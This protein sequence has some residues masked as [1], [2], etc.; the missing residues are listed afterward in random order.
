MNA[1]LITIGTLIVIYAITVYGLNVIVGYAGQ[2]SLG[3]AAF[4]GI[5]AYAAAL[6]STK[7]G[8]SFWQA[9]PIVIVLSGVILF[10]SPPGRIANWTDW[11]VLGLTKSE[12][13]GMHI[14]FT[15]VF[16]I[17]SLFHVWFN[18]RPLLSYFRGKVSS[19]FSFRW[20]WVIGLGLCALVY[21]G[22]RADWPPTSSLLAWNEELKE[23]WDEPAD[24]APIPHAELLNLAALAEKANVELDQALQRLD[25]AN[26]TGAQGNIIVKDLAAANS[27]SAQ[28][29]YEII[30]PSPAAGS[31]TANGHG[32][33]LGQF[34]LK[35][36]CEKENLD[37]SGSLQ[38]LAENNYQA[39]AEMTLK[40]IA[41]ENGF[42]RPFELVQLLRGK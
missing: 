28:S 18:W 6:L 41:A 13:A 33:G 20:E 4:F 35:E 10:I 24:R 37:L 3:H 22:L 12:W 25:Q 27:V 15:T 5:G 32:M 36:F 30:A 2:I 34:T 21:A 29:I 38:R 9:L 19:G 42:T 39:N 1:Y 16:I 11:N 8:L 31:S 26:I 40:E 23:S 14:V 7:A 17:A